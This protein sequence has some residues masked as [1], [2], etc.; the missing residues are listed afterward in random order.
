M[1]LISSPSILPAAAASI[2][3]QKNKYGVLAEGGTK[4]VT[5][6]F[7]N[8][9]ILLCIRASILIYALFC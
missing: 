7:Y 5:E 9:E 6:L 8:D 2:Q 3:Q 4:N 1:S